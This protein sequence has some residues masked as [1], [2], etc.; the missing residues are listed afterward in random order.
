MWYRRTQQIRRGELLLCSKHG[1]MPTPLAQ[2]QHGPKEKSSLSGKRTGAKFVNKTLALGRGLAIRLY[3]SMAV[4]CG[5][6]WSFAH[7]T[8]VEVLPVRFFVV[9]AKYATRRFCSTADHRARSFS[10]AKI[11]SQ[12]IVSLASI[13]RLRISIVAAFAANDLL[14]YSIAGRFFSPNK[15]KNVYV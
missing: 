5:T 7:G 10:R 4:S 8:R 9:I 3:A 14:S 1:K 2:G 6:F 12:H 13:I 15:Y 11:C